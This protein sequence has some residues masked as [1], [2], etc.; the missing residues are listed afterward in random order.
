M[1]RPQYD[2]QFELVIAHTTR[3]NIF[4]NLWLGLIEGICIIAT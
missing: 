1:I 2:Y 3:I 4:G